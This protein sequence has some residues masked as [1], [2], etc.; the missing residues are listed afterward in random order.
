[1]RLVPMNFRHRYRAVW[2]SYL[3]YAFLF[4]PIAK[5]IL[6]DKYGAITN[7]TAFGNG[8]YIGDLADEFKLHLKFPYSMNEDFTLSRYLRR[9]SLLEGRVFDSN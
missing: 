4:S 2:Q 3:R 5:T 9:R 1:M 8:F 7:A 6:P